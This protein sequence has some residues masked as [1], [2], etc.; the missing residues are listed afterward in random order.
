[1][2]PRSFRKHLLSWYL[3]NKRDLPWRNTMDPYR[4]WLSEIM[5]QQT[6]VAAVIPHYERFLERFPTIE[7]LAAA[8]EV[9]VLRQ[10]AGLGYYTRARN[11][12]KA[13]RQ[14][15]EQGEFPN[16][17]ERIRALAGIGDYTAAAV[18]SIAFGLPH[19]VLDGNV[20]RVV[21]RLDNDPSDIGSPRTRQRFQVRAQE[22][23][24]LTDPGA[25]N[26]AMMEL[27][28]TIC[29][30]KTPNCPAC[31]VARTCQGFQQGTQREL[32][33]KAR[34][35]QIL[36][37]EKTV[38]FI[39]RG[40]AIL[41][42]QRPP[43]SQKLQGFWEL[44]EAPQLPRAILGKPLGEF[45][46]SITNHDIRTNVVEARIRHIP[47]NFFYINRENLAKLPVTTATKKAL[48]CFTP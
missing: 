30:P 1:M 9:D 32:P 6:R 11:L 37:V 42:W 45:R 12:H 7:V 16:A 27:G 31:P 20:M 48:A 4:I 8:P 14:V 3:R 36:R 34:K 39:T 19:A 26:Q 25:A 5:L 13:A 23:L 21:S 44:P 15:V 43:E 46:H 40:T 47:N 35:Q 29:L 24:D 18:A 10:W 28:A 2:T 38:L 22:L 17:Y 33:V 41:M